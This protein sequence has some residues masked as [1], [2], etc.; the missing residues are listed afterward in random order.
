MP[1]AP[2]TNLIIEM[3]LKR[4][5]SIFYYENFIVLNKIDVLILFLLI[6]LSSIEVG[7]KKVTTN[8]IYF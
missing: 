3:V 4:S 7:Y 2:L 6:D 8:V 1:N 5:L